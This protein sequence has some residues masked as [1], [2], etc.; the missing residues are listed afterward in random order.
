ML[1]REEPKSYTGSKI[2]ALTG[3]VQTHCRTFELVPK[4]V[5]YFFPLS[6]YSKEGIPLIES[7]GSVIH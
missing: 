6:L 2:R 3:S 5:N 1:I 4:T 7:E